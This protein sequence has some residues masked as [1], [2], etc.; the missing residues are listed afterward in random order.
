MRIGTRVKVQVTMDTLARS[1]KAADAAARIVFPE[2]NA[3][4]QDAIGS[5][6]WYWPRTTIRRGS[7]RRDGTR[8]K[9]FPVTTPRNIVDLGTLRQ[10][11]SFQISGSRCTFR[12]SVGYATAVHYGANIHPY[13]D[14]SRP[15]VNLPARPWTSAVLGTISVPGVDR[16]DYRAQFR[17]QY[18]A[19]WRRL[20]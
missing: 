9:G 13:G 16:Y 19:A 11:N 18:I 6:V 7:L 8:G 1:R 10:S 3:A 4:F 14:R 15:L 12:W 20:S 17:A 5:K 2:L